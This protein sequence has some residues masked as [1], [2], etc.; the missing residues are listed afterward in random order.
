MSNGV[1]LSVLTGDWGSM[2]AQ[3]SKD[4]TS[5]ELLD[6]FVDAP[7]RTADHLFKHRS[8]FLKG[9]SS[10]AFRWFFFNLP[11]LRVR[12]EDRRFLKGMAEVLSYNGFDLVV[13]FAA[14]DIFNFLVYLGCALAGKGLP[15][16]LPLCS[17]FVVLPEVSA[18][19]AL[20]HGRNLDYAGGPLW[21]NSQSFVLVE[22]EKGVPFVMVTGEG[23]YLPGITATNKEG[24]TVGVN[25]LFVRGY[26]IIKRPVLTILSEVI[27]Q[28]RSLE[29][30]ERILKSSSTFAGWGIMVS[31]AKSGKAALFELSPYGAFRVDPSNGILCLT[32]TCLSTQLQ[33]KEYAPSATW[34]EHNHTRLL[35]LKRLLEES[36]GEFTAQRGLE[37]LSDHYDAFAHNTQILGNAI[38]MAGNVLSALFCPSRD[39]IW[40]SCGEA[41]LNSFGVYHAYSLGSLFKGELE[42]KRRVVTHPEIKDRVKGFRFFMESLRAW[43]E[44]LDLKGAIENMRLAVEE[45]P[46]EPLFRFL[47]ALLLAM[48]FEF[49]KALEELDAFEKLKIS[50]LRVAQ[51][52]LWKGRLYD[53]LDHREKAV[54]F[55]K[56]AVRLS[57]YK[58]IT[59]AAWLGMK[60]PYTAKELKQ[61]ELLFLVADWIE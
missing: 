59:D 1:S 36:R 4:T 41:P 14:P 33:L 58:D 8:P 28:A 35:R 44:R 25:M 31:D 7:S 18:D 2:G 20:C 50:A 57:R 17:S 6:Y 56:E 39:E 38:A 60:K 48:G 21:S 61:L 45:S 53:L 46:N 19:G 40:V 42:L 11:A 3:F 30:A 26:G 32:N 10:K 55:Y 54:E 9:V 29:D 43:D 5:T 15:H 51:T 52:K 34:V 22:P 13:T 12:S 24:I 49:A 27:S 23:L 37:I 47:L 16:V